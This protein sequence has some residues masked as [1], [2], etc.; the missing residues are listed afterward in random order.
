MP[1]MLA[2][3]VCTEKKKKREGEVKMYVYSV[4]AVGSFSVLL[5]N[6]MYYFRRAFFLML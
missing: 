1:V 2:R 6:I 4:S 3:R 5:W